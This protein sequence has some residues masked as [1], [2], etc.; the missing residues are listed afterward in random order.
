LFIN[1]DKFKIIN[2][3]HGHEVCDLLLIEVAQRLMNSVRSEDTVARLGGDEFVVLLEE[4]NSDPAVSKK[5]A[6]DIAE[7][8]RLNLNTPYLLKDK[9]YNSSSSIGVCLFSGTDVTVD[10]LLLRADKAMYAVQENGCDKCNMFEYSD[11]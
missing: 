5:Q 6:T 7:K 1:L 8:I 3:A 10:E 9:Q 2:D 11:N 4:L